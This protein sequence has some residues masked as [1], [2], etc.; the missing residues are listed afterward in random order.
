M[1]SIILS[2]LG[3]IPKRLLFEI[4]VIGGLVLSISILWKGYQREHSERNRLESNQSVLMS[5]LENYRISDSLNAARVDALNLTVSE[6]KKGFSELEG[7]LKEMHIKVK[8]LET[9]AITGTNTSYYITTPVRDS[10]VFVPVPDT[11]HAIRY[12][13][14]WLSLSGYIKNREFIGSIES[15][16]TL[17]QVVHRVP[18]R[19]L[20]IK[21]GT[22]GIRQ[23]IVSKNPHT[24]INY[25]KYIELKKR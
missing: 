9:V 25:A 23:E 24:T 2:L 7:L 21:Y 17:V 6:F 10:L 18:K 5:S 13:D 19:F 11:L 8:R 16:D 22:K 14:A 1:S 12:R 20:F 15:R 4:I 3:K